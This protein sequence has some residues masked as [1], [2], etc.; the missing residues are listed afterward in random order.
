MILEDIKK[1]GVVGAGTM[2]YGIAINFALWGY[3][4]I[5]SD[6]NDKILQQSVKNIKSA[7]SLFVKE[8]LITDEQ[9]DDTISRI[10]TTTD[11]AKLAINSDFITE[12]IIEKS[13]DKRK[14]FN[15]LDELCPPHTIIVSNTSSLVLSDFGSDVNR[16]DKIGITHYFAPPHIV[17]GV[18]VVK[19]PGTS[20]ETFD[21]TYSLLK[22]IRK[23]PIRVLKELPGYLLNRIQGAMSR[24]AN[25]L[26]AEGVATAEDIE[27]GVKSTFGFRMPHEGPMMHYDVAGI[28]KWPKD[29]RT[30]MSARRSNPE[31]EISAEAAQKI[32]QRMAEGKPWFVDPER[33][34]E[35]IEKRDTEYARR[36]K[37]LYWTK[38]R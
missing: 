27:L 11:L 14:L 8:E 19:G 21:I 1:V 9:A 25:R 16:Q 38:E 29:V 36:L 3:P 26:W 22:K 7:M 12:A 6:I 32:Q 35:A 17:P 18:E 10:A 13:T 2:G 23:I 34:D 28:W 15:Q 30:A 20:D 4:I 5:M 31:S 24:E 33:F 37:D